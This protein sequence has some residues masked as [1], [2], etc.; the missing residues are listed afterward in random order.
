MA[1]HAITQSWK[2]PLS[3]M[4]LIAGIR[5]SR[6]VRERGGLIRLVVASGAAHLDSS[7]GKAQVL[8]MLKWHTEIGEPLTGHDMALHAALVGNLRPQ[9]RRVA[10]QMSYQFTETV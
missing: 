4:T 8:E 9:R 6:D 7:R 1:A 3:E 5:R 10:P 2:S